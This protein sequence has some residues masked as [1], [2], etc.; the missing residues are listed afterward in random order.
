MYVG[1]ARD[2]LLGGSLEA[3]A[4]REKQVVVAPSGAGR[5]GHSAAKPARL[6]PANQERPIIG[7]VPGIMAQA[8]LTGFRYSVAS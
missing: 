2:K 1:R 4:I 8:P 3:W 6:S 5:L 7:G